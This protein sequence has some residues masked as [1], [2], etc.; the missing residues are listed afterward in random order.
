MMMHLLIRF[1]TTVMLLSA[2]YGAGSNDENIFEHQLWDQVVRE[3][4]TP[5][6]GFVRY[7][8][9]KQN[10][11]TLKQ[12]VRLVE[13]YSPDNAPE[14]FPT[15]DHKLAYWINAYNA[16]IVYRVIQNYPIDSIKDLGGL[17]S[18][19]FDKKQQVGGKQL[20][21]NDIEHKIIRKRFQEPR[22][23]FV[24][25]CAS[26]SC[27]PIQR[28][29]LTADN[30]EETLQTAT[31]EFLNNPNNVA[32][33]AAR[34]E[35]RLSK[36]FDWFDED[37]EDWVKKE[38]GVSNPTLLDYVKLYLSEDQRKVLQQ[39]D[40]WDI[41]SFDYDWSLNDAAKLTK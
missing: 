30:L 37:F 16:L 6:R 1:L 20:S 5:E 21:Y 29:A 36:Y 12:Y 34:R 31:V 15:R 9:L 11:D 3:Y 33:E 8:Q 23:H 26:Y 24:L 41:E 7:Q 2:L 10:P 27:A 19:V 14:M 28:H 38:K 25:N 35:V 22:I 40:D 17:F 39:H 18:S 32:I 4:V 13:K